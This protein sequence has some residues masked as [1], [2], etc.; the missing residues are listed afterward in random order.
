MRPPTHTRTHSNK[1]KKTAE[2]E[3]ICTREC[4]VL[5]AF[6]IRTAITI[7]TKINKQFNILRYAK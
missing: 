7:T 1:R 5:D 4:G 6:T 2:R 3:G